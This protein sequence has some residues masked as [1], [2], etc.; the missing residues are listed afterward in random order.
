MNLEGRRIWQVAAGDTNRSYG[1]LFT[2]WNVIAIGPGS[3]GPW[4]DCAEKMRND[5]WTARKVGDIRR[6]YEIADGDI[7]VLRIGTN[8]ILAVGIAEGPP[9][10]TEA[11]GDVDG[12]DLQHVRR[13][14]WLWHGFHQ[15][16]NAYTLDWGQ[17][18][19][20]GL[21]PA[22][23]EWL[24]A[25][26]LTEPTNP[27]PLPALPSPSPEINAEE[28]D[29]YFADD[30]CDTETIHR[31]AQAR[32]HVV[33]RHA[34][35]NKV[36]HEPSEYETIAYLVL[37]LL[38][39]L[40]WPET[41]TAIEWCRIDVA[42]FDTTIDASDTLRHDANLV[43][44]IEV[45]RLNYSCLTAKD[46]AATYAQQAGREDCQRLIVTDGLRYAVHVR[47]EDGQFSYYPTAYL[48]LARLRDQ[49][50]IMKCQGARTALR[51]M[52][53]EWGKSRAVR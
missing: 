46:Q 23:E 22:A 30:G 8:I 35:Y 40:G 25:L 6:F 44:A 34:W 42:L 41:H 24:K 3:Y 45:K 15:F 36:K 5:G 37:P 26:D 11:F 18:I 27:S 7:V 47:D 21:K 20:P 13:V 38:K 51:L 52:R 43:A 2:D 53:P 48:N 28:L 1:Q 10:H 12:W 17:T 16:P 50:P 29:A 33:S 9:S 4:P 39:A 49:Y 14:R 31:L 19:T 32:A